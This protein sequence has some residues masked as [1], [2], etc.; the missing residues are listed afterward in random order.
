MLTV[1]VA[2]PTVKFRLVASFRLVLPNVRPTP[3]ASVELAANTTGPF[4]VPVP[5]SA[6]PAFTVNDCV[7]LL[8]FPLRSSVP[9]F[10]VSAPL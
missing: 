4:V 7:A 8:E 10:T 6:A 9:P 3:G 2:D 5:P 1:V